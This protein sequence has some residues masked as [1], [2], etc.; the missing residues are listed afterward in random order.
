MPGPPYTGRHRTGRHRA[1]RR[2]A[3]ATGAVL[4][5]GVTSCAVGAVIVAV[6]AA[7]GPVAASPS[8]AKP[9][10]APARLTMAAQV[11][12]AQMEKQ[13]AVRR[14]RQ[15]AQAAR[16]SRSRSR[17]A[18]KAKQEAAAALRR[19]RSWVAPLAGYTLTSGFGPRWGRQHQGLDLAAATGA[20]IGAISSGTVIYAGVQGAYGNKVE[21]RHWDGTVSYYAHMSSIAVAVGQQ[22]SPGDKVGEVGSTGR[23]TGPHLH[24]QVLPRGAAVDGY[25]WL[26]ARGVRL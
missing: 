19:A 5:G 13:D 3:R 20:R 15:T 23:S 17:A 9:A 12:E 10:V 2:T 24:L 11:D 26:A 16:A 21:V 1:R 14:E 7:S 18:L 4:G 6:T 25:S 8:L 22:V